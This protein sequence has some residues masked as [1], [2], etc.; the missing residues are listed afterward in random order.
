MEAI[1]KGSKIKV[2]VTQ[3]QIA[4]RAYERWV[5][6]GA[7]DTD[8]RDDWFAARAELEAE[9][10]TAIAPKKIASAKRSASAKKAM[11]VEA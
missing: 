10:A 8:G 6:R 11:Q 9:L 1:M 3:K 4:V 5:G 7:P 2:E